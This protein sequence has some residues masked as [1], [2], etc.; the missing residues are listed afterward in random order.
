MPITP[1]TRFRTRSTGPARPETSGLA[2]LGIGMKAAGGD[3]TTNGRLCWL[4][5]GIKAARAVQ[6]AN[7]ISILQAVKDAD[8]KTSGDAVRKAI[9]QARSAGGHALVTL[10]GPGGP[11]KP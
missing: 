3:R 5:I 6:T 1:P 11:R 4:G 7:G 8:V 2:W 10:P 9:A